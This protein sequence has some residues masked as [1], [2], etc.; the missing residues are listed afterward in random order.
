MIRIATSNQRPAHWMAQFPLALL[1][2]AWLSVLTAPTYAEESAKTSPSG[3]S[4][5]VRETAVNL[6]KQ[7]WACD[8]AAA[9]RGVGIG[10]GEICG[11]IYEDLK[12]SKFGGDFPA[13]LGWWQQNKAAEYLALAAGG[14]T[15]AARTAGQLTSR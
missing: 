13:M 8:H 15:L 4:G 2:S 5:N 9:T 12:R 10:D 7:F 1:F 6:E 14:R 11:E 3:D